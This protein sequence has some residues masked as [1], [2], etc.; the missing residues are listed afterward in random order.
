MKSVWKLRKRDAA[1]EAAA[2]VQEELAAQ[3]GITRC[4]CGWSFIGSMLDGIAAAR[5]HRRDAHRP[6]SVADTADDRRRTVEGSRRHELE[7]AR[8]RVLAV[9]EDL[10]AEGRTAATSKTVGERAEVSAHAAGRMLGAAGYTSL[11]KGCWQLAP[12]PARE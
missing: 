1:A 12:A 4:D 2:R 6:R 3:D 11:R 10:R 5:E 9:V 7:E 8:R